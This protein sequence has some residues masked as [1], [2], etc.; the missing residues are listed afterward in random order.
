MDTPYKVVC[1]SKD[2][3]LHMGGRKKLTP[4]FPEGL[5]VKHYRQI[6]KLAG[7]VSQD[8]IPILIKVFTLF[9]RKCSR[10]TT[11]D[12]YLGRDDRISFLGE[13]RV[14]CPQLAALSFSSLE[15]VLLM[16]MLYDI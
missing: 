12:S 1:E 10:M 11:F 6:K 7:D 15:S 16:L 3:T 9:L 8:N 4:N 5:A 2:V 14:V 13:K